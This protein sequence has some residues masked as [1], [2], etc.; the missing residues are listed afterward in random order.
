MRFV[1]A[2]RH[3]FVVY[4]N[5]NCCPHVVRGDWYSKSDTVPCHDDGNMTKTR[6]LEHTRCSSRGHGHFPE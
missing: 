3:I 1:R 6:Q 4:V 2:E 5:I